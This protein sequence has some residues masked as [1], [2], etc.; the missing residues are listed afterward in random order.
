[1]LQ[2]VHRLFDVA[3]PCTAFF[4]QKDAQQLF[5]VRRM[6]A[7][8]HHLAAGITIEAC[9]TIRD[10][11]GLAVSSR[12]AYL[13][14]AEREQ[15]GCLFLALSEAAEA[16]RGGTRDP[17]VLVALMAREIGATPLARPV[18]AAVVDDATF[19]PA[20]TLAAGRPARAIVSVAFPSVRLIDNVALPEPPT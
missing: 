11:D 6:V 20:T 19:E 17:A 9:P 18:Y 12:N 2:V 4:G 10:P 3:G 8:V 13:S 14:A 7:Q 1:V 16:A 15:A 5:L